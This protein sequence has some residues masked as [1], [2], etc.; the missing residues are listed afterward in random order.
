[1]SVFENFWDQKAKNY[2]KNGGELTKFQLEFLKLIKS[3]GVVFKDK[4]IID[5][6]CGT[7]NYTLH[8]AKE[9]KKIYGI[10]SSKGMLNELEAKCKN[11][12]LTNVSWDQIDFANYK[13]SEKFDIAFLTMTPAVSS[14]EFEKFINLAHLKVYLNWEKERFSSVLSPLFAILGKKSKIS[15]AF[16]LTKFL[17]SKNIP[18]KTKILEEIRVE[19]REFDKALE[20]AKW[21]LNISKLEIPEKKL[22]DY[23]Q[24]L[25]IDGIIKEKIIS[26]TRAIVF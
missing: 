11:L 12:K 3:W 20:N 14:S 2:D 22:I 19:K 6:G 8:L 26:T 7:G 13:P 25:S 1:M 23:L 18:F 10:D 21:H 5:I 16:L 9:C 17:E 24:S 4:N 15:D